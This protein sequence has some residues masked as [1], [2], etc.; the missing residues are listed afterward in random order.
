MSES[1]YAEHP[2]AWLTRGSDDGPMFVIDAYRT[3]DVILSKYADQDDAEPEQSV[4]I[5]SV[6]KE[7]VVELWASLSKGEFERIR[8][9]CPDCK[10]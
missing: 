5:R 1:D 2:N 9:M 7:V 3:G 8:A 6:S 10:W 4:T